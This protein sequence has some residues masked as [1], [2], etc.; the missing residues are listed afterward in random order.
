LKKIITASLAFLLI[1]NTFF[2]GFSYAE[3]TTTKSSVDASLSSPIEPQVNT[4]SNAEIPTSSSSQKKTSNSSTETTTNS[5]TATKPNSTPSPIKPQPLASDTGTATYGGVDL[6]E[7]NNELSYTLDKAKSAKDRLSINVKYDGDP[8]TT[9]RK[10][11]IRLKN[12]LGIDSSAPGMI[13]TSE[14]KDNWVFDPN[15]LKG[16]Q[17]TGVI[18]NATYTPDVP[19]DG[20]TPKSG[21]L[22]YEFSSGTNNLDLSLLTAFDMGFGG[23]EGSRSFENI[24]EVTATQTV[25]GVPTTVLDEKWESYTVTGKMGPLFRNVTSG[26]TI[27][28]GDT[29][30]LKFSLANKGEKFPN[31][32][33]GVAYKE[34]VH[35]FSFDKKLGFDS[36]ESLDTSSGKLDPSQFE[37][38]VDSTS[39]PNNDLVTLKVKNYQANYQQLA[40][41]FNTLEDAEPGAY[42]IKANTFS[43]KPIL[44]SEAYDY[45]ESETQ[46]ITISQ[47]F[48][49]KL[50]V[51]ETPVGTLVTSPDVLATKDYPLG[52]YYLNNEYASI[53]NDQQVKLTFNDDTIGVTSVQLV[54]GKSEAAKNV[55]ITTN[56]STY[57]VDNIAWNKN[58]HNTGTAMLYLKDYTTAADEY[59]KEVIYESTNFQPASGKNSGVATTFMN[60]NIHPGSFYGTILKPENEGYQAT[61]STVPIEEEWD[62]DLVSQATTNMKL[63]NA[64]KFTFRYS[65]LDKTKMADGLTYTAGERFTMYS[66]L[67][68][69]VNQY[70][71]AYVKKGFDIYLREGEYLNIDVASIVAKQGDEEYSVANGKLIPVI[72]DDNTGNKVIKFTLSDVTL[73][74]QANTTT[75]PGINLS[76]DV[77]I[78]NSTPTTS[79][80]A[81]DLLAIL[82][83]DNELVSSIG[84]T[85][86]F[87][88]SNKYNIDGSGDLKKLVG[89]LT[90]RTILTIKERKDFD[91]TTAVNLD[92]GPW[93]SYDFDTNES[94]IDLNPEGTVKYQLSVLNNSDSE[95]DGYTALV[96]IPKAGEQTALTPSTP[97]EFVYGEHLQKEAFTW[98]TSLLEEVQPQ[99]NLQYQIFYATTY[100]IDKDSPNFKTW[101]EISDKDDIRMVKIITMDKIPVDYSES[102]DFPL[103]LTDPDAEKN[104]GKTNIYSARIYREI[105]GTS[106]YKPSEP[107]AIR[108]QTGVVSGQVFNDANRNGIK[109]NGETGRNGVTVLAYE[110]GTNQTKLI[111]ST[112]TKTMTGQDGCYQFLGLSKLNDVDIV[113]VN[114]ATDG[115]LHFSD[116]TEDGST[117][118]PNADHLQAITAAVTPSNHD[119]NKI[120]VGLIE[121]LTITFNAGQGSVVN[122]TVTRFP[123]EKI[124]EEPTAELTGHTF[125]GWYTEENAGTRVDFPYTVGKKNAT[126]YARYEK[127]KY[128]VYYHNDGTETQKSVLYDEFLEEPPTPSKTGQT[129]IGW[130]T[131]P[132]G[133]HAWDFDT[134][135]MPA[136]RLD[137]YARFGVGVYKVTF[138]TGEE[139][140]EYAYEYNKPIA[141]PSV[142]PVKTGY[143]FDGWYTAKT[144]GTK[145][146]FA[147][148][149]MPG[150]DI[151]LYAHFKINKYA[152]NYVVDGTTVKTVQIN[153]DALVADKPTD[154]T[155]EGHTFEGWFNEET[156]AEWNFAEDKVPASELTL[157]A[158]FKKNNYKLTFNNDGQTDEQT[159]P[160]DELAEIPSA[161]AKTGYTF[162][163]WF[164][165]ATG[166]TQWDFSTNR[167]PARNMTLYAHYEINQYQVT[168]DAQGT[169]TTETVEY[170]GLI[171]KPATDP[172]A[173]DGYEFVGWQ[174]QNSD[175][176]WDFANDKMPANDLV[177]VAQF[178]A[179]DQVI[180]LDFDGGTSDGPSEI[181]APT[182][183]RVDIDA[184]TIPT[185]PGYQFVGWFD[186]ETQVSGTIT[187]P[188]G[189]LTLKAKWE[190]ADQVIRFDANGGTGVD[191]V[192]AKT[193]TVITIEDY[194]TTRDG[195]EFVGWFDEN[196]QQVTGEFTVP[197]GGATFIAKWQALDQTITFDVNGG[198]IATQ[199][200]AIVKPTG[201]E[202]DLSAISNPKRLNHTFKG[203]V[204]E[205][206][207]KYTGKIKMPAGGLVL[208]AQW[209]KEP[210]KVDT[211]KANNGSNNNVN[212]NTGTN[213]KTDNVKQNTAKDQK[214]ADEKALPNNGEKVTPFVSVI[215]LVLLA[216]AAV[217]FQLKRK[218]NVK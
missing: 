171:T 177:L 184:I 36:I 172:Q 73:G 98:T 205:S 68:I 144:G 71:G 18:V 125:K 49:N 17:Y 62:S 92:D 180:T 79:I 7:E 37:F 115:S 99:G 4:S 35:I 181:T 133:G 61:V 53:V 2:P 215:G 179:L 12:G 134:D 30:T 87:N 28:A 14:A 127:N 41:T 101:D 55:K 135:K 110:A 102:I 175:K 218:K 145:W 100:E 152:V 151:T 161:P 202:I 212:N 16:T 74:V 81:Q 162:I 140:K 193:N 116:P 123:N 121:P 128:D 38:T 21:T 93:V 84:N 203:W 155:K 39:D 200:E 82:P 10:L 117:A 90:D 129:F 154:P 207:K 8:S 78:K 186:E 142:D 118:T 137:L 72:M 46:V 208:T 23:N 130:F 126:F 24:I 195:Y 120:H 168:F 198:D 3:V 191:S 173:A 60:W 174:A 107:V 42:N 91:V 166:G 103:A 97:E 20:Y 160:Y 194:T 164:D 11:T 189:G 109:D 146:D 199:P 25:S 45:G 57:E 105:A 58:L 183:S 150:E 131:D 153:Y 157:T 51:K 6:A 95:I 138:D 188:V 22:V 124:T 190:E 113:F 119:F 178:K 210:V 70:Y 96:P 216:L 67:N 204:D 65:D 213:S 170:N 185:K 64:T 69:G 114:P 40:F 88:H 197:A 176:L 209:E 187:M 132:T 89:T 94:I 80:N 108:L 77:K 169:Q 147:Q 211:D 13:A 5:T 9:D 148:D 33:G 217:L 159:V 86:Y 47:P 44:Y 59:I 167:M 141:K 66:N 19:V 54:T 29:I 201:T 1:G 163:G 52:I 182:D 106:G 31:S 48:V 192:V 34:V 83:S 15:A 111:A 63:S 196:D 136:E 27:N 104:A 43:T 158:R 122:G 149:K 32:E 112:V 85:A 214:Q 165:Q 206:G 26:G 75:Y 56:K 139:T 143:T 50:T 156:G 76:Y